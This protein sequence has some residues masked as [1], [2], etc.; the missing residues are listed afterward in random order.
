MAMIY[1]MNRCPYSEMLTPKAHPRVSRIVTEF[2]EVADDLE[3]M[4]SPSSRPIRITLRP[5]TPPM[6]MLLE[7]NQLEISFH[8]NIRRYALN[9]DLA[10]KEL[11]SKL[12]RFRTQSS[13]AEVRRAAAVTMDII[14]QAIH[15]FIIMNFAS[16]SPTNTHH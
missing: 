5:D 2:N 9:K 7:I 1:A 10:V 16:P 8:S 3:R 4:P 6:E 11:F 14:C 12:E 15:S 13:D